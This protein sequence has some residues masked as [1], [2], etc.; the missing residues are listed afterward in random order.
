MSCNRSAEYAATIQAAGG[1][2]AHGQSACCC[3][4]G[5]GWFHCRIDGRKQTIVAEI[6]RSFTT[7]INDIRQQ[8]RRIAS[9]ASQESTAKQS[10]GTGP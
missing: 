7:G 5:P 3:R 9:Y 6:I 1:S 10:K 4:L 2:D 8:L